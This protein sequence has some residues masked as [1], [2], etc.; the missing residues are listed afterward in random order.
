MSTKDKLRLLGCG[1]GVLGL[2]GI[3]LDWSAWVVIPSV[4][5]SFGIL[6]TVV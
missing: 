6:E 2:T 3:F 5:I 4:F 1:L